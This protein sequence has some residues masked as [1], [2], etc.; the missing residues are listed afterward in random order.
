MTFLL[1]REPNRQNVK[2]QDK[3]LQKIDH[4]IP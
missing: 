2:I 1:A 4:S 3:Q